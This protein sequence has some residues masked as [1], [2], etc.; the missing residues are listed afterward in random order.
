MPSPHNLAS[1][2][3]ESCLHMYTNNMRTKKIKNTLNTTGCKFEQCLPQLYVMLGGQRGAPLQIGTVCCKG[4][5]PSRMWPPADLVRPLDNQRIDCVVTT[6]RTPSAPHGF[7]NS[8]ATTAAKRMQDNTK[9]ICNLALRLWEWQWNSDRI[10]H[11]CVLDMAVVGAMLVPQSNWH[12]IFGV[13]TRMLYM[14]TLCA[15]WAQI[16]P[17]RRLGF[18]VYRTR[19]NMRGDTTWRPRRCHHNF[20]DWRLRRP[21]IGRSGYMY[22]VHVYTDPKHCADR[23]LGPLGCRVLGSMCLEALRVVRV[24]AGRENNVAMEGRESPRMHPTTHAGR[25]KRRDAKMWLRETVKHAVAGLEKS[26]CPCTIC[27]FGRPLLR[28]TQ[29]RHL[30]NYGRHP[31]KRLQEQVC[32]TSIPHIA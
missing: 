14:C 27:M 1:N 19:V 21:H 11:E 26:R 30:R 10:S 24:L 20:G 12:C 8:F 23:E 29:V 13:H 4:D 2:E 6:S 17:R 31:V 18:W 7:A 15:S 16:A 3:H 5:S 25:I 22:G 9:S 32:P 28:S